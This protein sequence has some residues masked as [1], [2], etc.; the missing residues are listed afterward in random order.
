MRRSIATTLIAIVTAVIWLAPAIAGTV[1]LNASPADV[2]VACANAGG[3]P[4][5]G[6]GTGGYGCKGKKGEIEC[7]KNSN[8]TGT[9]QKCGSA[10]IKGKGGV[11]GTILVP[12]ALNMNST[13]SSSKGNTVINRPPSS[14]LLENS[15][16]G[17]SAGSTSTGKNQ[18]NRSVTMPTTGSP[19][20]MRQ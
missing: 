3:T 1:S 14:G 7:D 18:P 12:R 13:T 19:S 6:T 4:T 17:V 16:G 8:C 11:L 2:N 10:S 20:L 9:C 15:A 5:S